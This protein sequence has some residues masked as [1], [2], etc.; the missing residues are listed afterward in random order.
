MRHPPSSAYNGLTIVMSNPSR[1]DTKYLLSGN[2][3]DWFEQN[4]LNPLTSRVNC[5][6]RTKDHHEKLLPETRALL[7]LGESALAEWCNTNV[8]IHKLRGSLLGI[9]INGFS[10]PV[11]T[12]YLPQDAQDIK[13]YETTHNTLLQ[14]QEDEEDDE[15]TNTEK[16][17]GR[18]KRENW[19]FWLQCDTKKAIGLAR[20]GVKAASFLPEYSIFPPMSEALDVLDKRGSTLYIDIETDINRS[21]SCI[22]Y[23]FSDSPII[24]VIPLRTFDYKP[25]YP[26][27]HR[28]LLQLGKAL[29]SNKVVAHNGSGFDFLVLAQKYSLGI[30]RDV[31][32]TMLAQSRCFPGI[33]KSLGHCIS[34][35]TYERYH[36]DDG[37]FMPNNT[38]QDYR[39]WKYNGR[40]VYTM[41][42]VHEAQL[43]YARVI[44]GLMDSINQVNASIR[45]YLIN[46]LMGIRF[47]QSKR[48]ALLNYNDRCMTQYIRCI[49]HLA[50]YQVLPTS[51]KQCVQ[52]FHGLL[53]L[54]VVGKTPTGNPSLNEKNMLKLKLKVPDNA[55]IDFCLAYRRCQKQSGSLGFLAY[56]E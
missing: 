1:F 53:N 44:P 37:V 6:I 48:Q 29:R 50:G 17:H 10:I 18:T 43:K 3:G 55:A 35:W 8:S 33:E 14:G 51:N 22:G 28:L 32:D 20:E 12:S 2:A 7:I 25:A 9:N 16:D 54:P 46:T 42:L 15:D 19:K 23:N 24:Y 40:D 47:D 52:Y 49:K 45:P 30:G 26:D 39:L 21:I 56:M 38:E 31:Y 41:R 13:D 11:I 27:V 36:K 5:D 4:C 34:M